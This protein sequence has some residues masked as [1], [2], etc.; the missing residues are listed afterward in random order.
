M[1]KDFSD[2]F[3]F[4]IP[5]EF[6]K[7]EKNGKQEMYVKGVA[8]SEVEDS[9][10]ET[11]VPAGYDLTPLLN[12]GFL[13]YNH[14]AGK[15]PDAIIGE[16]T[17]AEIINNGKELY[18][19][20]FLYPDS[21]SAQKTYKLAQVLEKNSPNRRMGFSIEGK[22]LERDPLNPKRI[23][24]ARITG[25]AITPCPKNPNTLLSIMKGEYSEP[26]V[27]IDEE[28]EKGGPGSGRRPGLQVH[29]TKDNKKY[30]GKITSIKPSGRYTVESSNENGK[31]QHDIHEDEIDKAMTAIA[32]EGTTQTESVAGSKKVFE[33]LLD[34]KNL[35]KNAHLKKSEVYTLIINRYSDF[36][37]S[38]IEKAKQI[39]SLVKEFNSK[40]S[41][42]ENNNSEILTKAVEH[43]FSF[44]DE[45]I[46]EIQKSEAQ[47]KEEVEKSS[48]KEVEEE[49]VEK[50]EEV[51]DLEKGVKEEF[52]IEE[53]PVQSSK[54]GGV[55]VYLKNII[56]ESL[57]KGESPED[58]IKE[59]VEKGCENDFVHNL[60]KSI[61]DEMS[62]LE[63]NGGIKGDGLDIKVQEVESSTHSSNPELQKS[64][65]VELLKGEINS[66]QGNQTRLVQGIEERFQSLATILKSQNNEFL[67]L[68]SVA[69][70]L[71][72]ENDFLKK[73]LSEQNSK[74]E[75]F[76]STPQR[77]RTV[78]SVKQVERFQNLEKSESAGKDVYSLSNKGDVEALKGKLSGEFETRIQKGE[79]TLA[80]GNALLELDFAKSMQKSTIASIE[81]VLSS[82]NILVTE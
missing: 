15:D 54:Y 81:N 65:E 31:I 8:S 68:R 12:K 66:L 52:K 45:K 22:A 18:I 33:E 64:E 3:N 6:S 10:G 19:E 75:Q 58:I 9:D 70:E 69:E 17:K 57:S 62:A 25:V 43:A 76:A 53:T 7:G 26:F 73:S 79:N 82:L 13:N 80:L 51:S 50:S 40:L 38:D 77:S 21:E 23:T 61:Q 71:K 59:L 4:F 42:M 1:V 48:E 37:N 14:Q 39:F 11:L 5:A 16:P 72:R 28:L 49:E 44:I 56:K 74:L 27:E 30:S 24:K 32:G 20:G 67:E 46:E 47:S 34:E 29:Y 2:K 78:T 41:D 63:A 36:F 35:P 60:V 55:E